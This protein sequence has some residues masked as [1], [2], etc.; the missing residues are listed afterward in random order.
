MR[1]K[2]TY[3]GIKADV[4]P[5]VVDTGG[6]NK[7]REINIVNTSENRESN[8]KHIVTNKY[9]VIE[10]VLFSPYTSHDRK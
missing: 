5:Y 7:D 3:P 1:R 9:I 4:N 8:I 10:C 2:C 6:M